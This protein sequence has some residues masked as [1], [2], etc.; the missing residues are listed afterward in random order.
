M[1]IIPSQRCHPA[2]L[3][4]STIPGNDGMHSVKLLLQ[5]NVQFFSSRVHVCTH[6]STYA[7]TRRRTVHIRHLAK[8]TSLD[9]RSF[10]FGELRHAVTSSFN[11]RFNRA[12]KT[13]QEPKKETGVK[14]RALHSNADCD[15]RQEV[16]AM[17]IIPSATSTC[18]MYYCLNEFLFT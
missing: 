15:W 5:Y 6:F 2:N 18:S 7:N 10:I 16:A 9:H 1:I 4:A 3:T 11:I 8:V 14:R 13:E 12:E 17:K